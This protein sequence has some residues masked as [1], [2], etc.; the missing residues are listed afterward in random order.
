MQW[1]VVQTV[2][3]LHDT[4]IVVPKWMVWMFLSSVDLKIDRSIVQASYINFIIK[5]STVFKLLQNV[6]KMILG[7]Q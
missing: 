6:S 1:L 5:I 3:F 7:V 4:N 2:A